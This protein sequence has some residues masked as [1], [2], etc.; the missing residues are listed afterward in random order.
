[1]ITS[2]DS[3]LRRSSSASHELIAPHVHFDVNANGDGIGPDNLN[4]SSSVE[5]TFR[6]LRDRIDELEQAKVRNF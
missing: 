3:S 1:M 2:G 5:I 4:I 6:Y